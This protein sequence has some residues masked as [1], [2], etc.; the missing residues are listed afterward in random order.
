II[1]AELNINIQLMRINLANGEVIHFGLPAGD[2][3][4]YYSIEI[5]ED[6]SVYYLRYSSLGL[7]DSGLF[8]FR[9]NGLPEYLGYSDEFAFNQLVASRNV[10]FGFGS[11]SGYA[12]D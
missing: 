5:S 7:G 8:R 4:D 3:S 9:F 1:V 11:Q 6:G 10:L 2:G 12:F